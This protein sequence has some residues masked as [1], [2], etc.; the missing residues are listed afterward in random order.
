M[1]S[2]SVVS[3]LRKR[4][5]LQPDDVAFLGAIQAGLIAVP[6]SVPQPGSHDERVAAVL[7]DTTPTVVLTTSAAAATVNDSLHRPESP[8]PAVIAVD[9][10]EPEPAE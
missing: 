5:G 6:L 7:A 4:A 1:Q 9:A 10:L 3:V 2:S 8:A